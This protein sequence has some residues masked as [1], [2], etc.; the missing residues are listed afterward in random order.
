MVE[1]DVP[2]EDTPHL[3][4]GLGPV[5][6]LQEGV[7][8]AD[9]VEAL[10]GGVRR[11][12]LL[13]AALG[14]EAVHGGVE[15]GHHV[16]GNG[17]RHDQVAVAIEGLALLVGQLIVEYLG[18]HPLTSPAPRRARPGRRFRYPKYSCFLEEVVP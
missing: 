14:L 12:P 9:E 17:V 4:E 3:G 1:L 7:V 11:Q 2:A 10:D 15:V 6:K 5:E 13:G 18:V 16:H 8:P